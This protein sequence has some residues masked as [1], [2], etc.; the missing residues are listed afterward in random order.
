MPTYNYAFSGGIDAIT[1]FGDRWNFL[2]GGTWANRFPYEFWSVDLTTGGLGD[3]TI[4]TGELSDLVP[5][6]AFTFRGRVYLGLGS[7]FNFSDNNDPTA[8]EVQDPGAGFQPF[9]GQYGAQDIIAGFA[10]LQGRLAVIGRRSVQVWTVNGDP[11]QFTLDQILDNVGTF[12]PLSIQQLGDSDAL[13][14][15]DTGVRSLRSKEV[16][17]NAYVDDIGSPIDGFIQA[18]LAGL[19]PGTA[20]A[21]CAITEPLTKNYWL[22]LNGTIYVLSR[23][24]SAKI[25]AWSTF[26]PRGND[27]ALF[28]PQKF[29]AYQGFVYVRTA[30]NLYRY[31]GTNNTTYDAFSQVT[32]QS[33][34]LN[35]KKPGVDK[36]FTALG[37]V[38][39]GSWTLKVC[40][41]PQSGT[42]VPVYN[43]GDA[44]TPSSLTD[45]T[46]DIG[47]FPIHMLGTHISVQG[48]SANASTS[49]PVILSSLLL[50]YN[51][52][53]VQ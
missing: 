1:G 46:Y 14:L 7:Q 6:V 19:A 22:Y 43:H 29:V 32:F 18:A 15:D 35:D 36:T 53:D 45:S 24:P 4:G 16:T 25:T 33:P 10:V 41:D 11:G 52:A 5:T 37:G 39:Q 40:T 30:R 17:L 9:L 49:R 20:A 28:V 26:E 27:N 12:A 3:F 38:L 21:A 47:R 50:Y 31:G 44:A 8:Y 23:H 48:V 42:F 34:W 2:F 51:H 13:L